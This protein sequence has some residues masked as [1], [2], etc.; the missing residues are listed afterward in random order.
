MIRKTIHI[1]NKYSEDIHIDLRCREDIKNAPAIIIVHGFKGFKNWGFFPDLSERLAIAGYVTVTANFSRNGI[2]YDYNTFKELDKFAQNTVSHE[3]DDLQ[4]IIE[5]IK[6]EN[7][8]KKTIDLEKLALL[9]HSKGGAI[10]ILKAAELG[11]GIQAIVTLASVS[12]FFRFTDDQIKQWNKK[13]VIEVE[14]SRTKQ[15]MPINKT[16]WDDLNKNK[17]KFDVLKA[18]ENLSIPALFIHGNS[19][20]TVSYTE[21]ENIYESCSSYVK[22]LEIIED[23]SHT[24]GITH[25]FQSASEQYLI[26]CDLIENWFDNYLSY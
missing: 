2:G 8:A 9:G 20:E 18:A 1:K 10:S 3:L 16:F 7:I 19:D 4:S 12:S 24:F 13:G 11:D 17:K 15:M 23:C 5:N 26:A 25:P 22:R 6:N 21:S 14:N